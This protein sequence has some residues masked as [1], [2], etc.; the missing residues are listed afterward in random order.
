MKKGFKNPSGSDVSFAFAF[1]H[2]PRTLNVRSYLLKRGYR[3]S[4]GSI[5]VRISL[6]RV[7]R[8][9]ELNVVTS[10]S[11]YRVPYRPVK[12]LYVEAYSL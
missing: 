4:T 8:S 9:L 6:I 3:T 12:Y 11:S 7:G 2:Y 10:P 5:G 1:A